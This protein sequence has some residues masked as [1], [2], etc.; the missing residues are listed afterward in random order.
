M[1]QKQ[2]DEQAEAQPSTDPTIHY[3]DVDQGAVGQPT[4]GGS[5]AGV[6]VG[7]DPEVL[8]KIRERQDEE[9][10][11]AE[12]SQQDVEERDEADREEVAQ[13]RAEEAEEQRQR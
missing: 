8:E 11:A 6:V 1:T 5:T 9:Q 4:E 2:T 10:Q 7:Q 3:Q 12:Q 13:A